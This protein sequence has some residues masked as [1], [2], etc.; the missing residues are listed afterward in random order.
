MLIREALEEIRSRLS[1]DAE[2]VASRCWSDARL[3]RIVHGQIRGIATDL[4]DSDREFYAAEIDLYAEDAVAVHS[5]LWVYS[6]PPFVHAIIEDGVRERSEPT[7]ARKGPEFRNPMPRPI[8]DGWVLDDDGALRLQASEAK[9]LIV[10]VAKMPARPFWATLSEP[11]A[12]PSQVVLPVAS[13]ITGGV[14][15]ELDAYI[16][17]S[18]T[19]SY[20]PPAFDQ[21]VVGEVRRVVVSR[22]AAVA[23][24]SRVE[25][26]LRNGFS[27]PLA[28]GAIVE[29]VVQVP[30]F[31]VEY[32][33]MQSTMLAMAPKNRPVTDAMAAMAR[34]EAARFLS[35]RHR[36]DSGAKHFAPQVEAMDRAR[37][38]SEDFYLDY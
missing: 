32:L 2:D 21:V 17:M 11:G 33:L 15:V 20:Q 38:N 8:R 12:D 26:L 28:Q 23:G 36:D 25:L 35:A 19:C 7:E 16:G 27:A 37:R 5:N 34:I 13:S 14:H 9:N 1:D 31:A 4:V 3:L 29:S 6:L 18:I 22:A 30:E 10:R 24:S